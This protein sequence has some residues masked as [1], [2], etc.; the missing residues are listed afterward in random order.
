M[1]VLCDLLILVGIVILLPL[2]AAVAIKYID[3]LFDRF[4]V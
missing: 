2:V 3:W 4:D 1:N